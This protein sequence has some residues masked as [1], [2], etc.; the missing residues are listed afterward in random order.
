MI[1]I[2]YNAL[3]NKDSKISFTKEEAQD[4]TKAIKN[5]VTITSTVMTSA[6]AIYI[7]AQAITTIQVGGGG[8]ECVAINPKTGDVIRDKQGNPV[9]IDQSVENNISLYGGI[10]IQ[11]KR[12]CVKS[13]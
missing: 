7:I 1:D 9:V 12:N 6:V 4:Q 3:E 5:A 10:M 2:L 8:L 11:V 13:K